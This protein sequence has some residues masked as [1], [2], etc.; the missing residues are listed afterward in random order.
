MSHMVKEVS[1]QIFRLLIYKNEDATNNR[2]S[3]KTV[4]R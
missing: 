1:M 3:E 2:S 4:L